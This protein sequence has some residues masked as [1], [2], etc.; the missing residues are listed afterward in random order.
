MSDNESESGKTGRFPWL[1]DTN[2]GEWAMRMEA[3]MIRKGLIGMIEL[4]VPDGKTPAEFEAEVEKA[5][6]KRSKTKMAEARAA[7]IERAEKSQLAHMRDKD[8]LIIWETLAKVHRARGLATRLALRRKLLS[9]SKGSESMQAWIGKVKGVVW[10]LEEI[11][12]KVDNEDVILALTM[13]LDDSYDSFVIS[14]DSTPTDDLDLEFVINR[15]LNEEARRNG[16]EVTAK[17]E[18]TAWPDNR[19]M[20]AKDGG[21]AGSGGAQ[22]GCWRCGKQGHIRAFCTEKPPKKTE[23]D[24]HESANLATTVPTTTFAL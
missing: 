24:A 13:G 18:N 1:N 8:P 23:E 2:Y 20:T 11:G 21:M 17:S 5:K 9:S 6:G 4:D 12:V 22:T 16:K 3:V 15:L 7:M 14:L 10:D 19:A